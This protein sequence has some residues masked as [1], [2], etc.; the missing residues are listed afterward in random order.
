MK[1]FLILN[2]F[3]S[4]LSFGGQVKDLFVFE[5]NPKLTSSQTNLRVPL[6]EQ[7]FNQA[8]VMT[9][10]QTR[11]SF[12]SHFSGTWESLEELLKDLS[13]LPA[14]LEVQLVHSS[15]PMGYH[16][17][18]RKVYLELLADLARFY[19]AENSNRLKIVFNLNDLSLVEQILEH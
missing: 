2:L 8:R 5:A 7:L 9:R 10:I 11:L 13:W 19:R 17:E 14:N 12:P 4:A 18:D 1:F 6:S 16:P 15:L 3:L